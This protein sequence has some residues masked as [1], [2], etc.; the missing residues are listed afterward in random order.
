MYLEISIT[1]QNQNVIANERKYGALSKFWNPDV[2][3]TELKTFSL[4]KMDND[5]Y[6]RGIKGTLAPNGELLLD[7]ITS[8]EQKLERAR[9]MV[10]FKISWSS[11]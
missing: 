7:V 10:Q 6:V 3:D 5:E 4:L 11:V 2:N 8:R 1:C 9:V